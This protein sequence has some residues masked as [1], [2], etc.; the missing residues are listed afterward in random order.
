MLMGM[1]IVQAYNPVRI[2]D[3][4]W[5]KNTPQQMQLV[6]DVSEPIQARVFHLSPMAGKP[7]R[8]V[9]DLSNASLVGKLPAL[10]FGNQ[11]I[12]RIRSAKH[13]PGVW[14]VVLDMNRP[15]QYQSHRLAPGKGFGHRLLIKLSDPS[16]GVSGQNKF[17]PAPFTPTPYA[18]TGYNQ[19]IAVIAID[20]GHGGVD[21]GAVGKQGSYEKNAV[22]AIAKRLAFWVQ[23]TPGMRPV[24]IRDGD[25]FLRLRERINR[26]R[27]YQAD[28]FISI[29]ADAQPR[30][31][32]HAQGSSVYILS[33]GAA[34]NEA[35]RW[36]AAKENNA[37]L[38]GGIRLDDKDDVLASVLLDLSQTGT[39]EASGHLASNV[40]RSLAKTQPLHQ[41]SV[42]Q[43]GFMVLRSPDIPS[44]LVETAFISNANEERKLNSPHHQDLIAQQ[45]LRGIQSYLQQFPFRKQ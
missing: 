33:L 8:V 5:A 37:D 41:S 28:L 16:S 34:S 22:L 11:L 21:P 30:G 3:M 29:H 4:R 24:L 23:K 19:H 1:N 10:P 7:Y 17:T 26:A 36:L 13:K 12:Q 44:I 45:I 32:H 35:A 38:L 9:I 25:Y 43:A 31:K 40:L 6:F 18:N 2:L 27:A 42:Q 20:A 39:L 15:V 14:R